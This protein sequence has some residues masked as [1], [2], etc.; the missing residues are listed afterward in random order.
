MKG[1]I[2]LSIALLASNFLLFTSCKK[3]EL[4]EETSFVN[5]SISKLFSDSPPMDVYVNGTLNSSMLEG[6]QAISVLVTANG[7]RTEISIKKH[8]E[9]NVL[10]DTVLTNIPKGTGLTYLYNEALGFNQFIG[11]DFRRPSSDSIA[12]QCVNNFNYGSGKINVY[13]YKSVD[14][15]TYSDTDIVDSLTNVEMNKLS[16]VVALPY[17]GGDGQRILYTTVVKDA[18]TGY[19][20]TAQ[21]F[22]DNGLD[23][24]GGGWPI[25][26]TPTDLVPGKLSIMKLENLPFDQNDIHY[27][28]INMTTIFEY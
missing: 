12:F 11:S 6:E 14:G 7:G 10:I 5:V 1:K 21:Y 16:G 24:H 27:E 2:V 9:S 26:A 25:S 8:G 22:I 4:M 23:P 17:N 15:Y 13:I 19:D 3:G 18:V 28:L 20:G